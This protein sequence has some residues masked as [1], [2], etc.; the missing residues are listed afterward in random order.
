[1]ETGRR[2]AGDTFAYDLWSGI[3]S[4][5]EGLGAAIRWRETQFD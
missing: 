2:A 5:K 3:E 1:M 4:A